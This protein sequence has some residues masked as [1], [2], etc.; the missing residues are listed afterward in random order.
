MFILSTLCPP[1]L[2]VSMS[3]VT[4]LIKTSHNKGSDTR[5]EKYSVFRFLEIVL[6]VERL[7]THTV[8]HDQLGVS[9]LP[10]AT[11]THG[12]KGLGMTDLILEMTKNK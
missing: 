8:Q 3:H 10:K 5:R 1:S 9:A 11:G 12:L 4:F 7:D 2:F 6:K